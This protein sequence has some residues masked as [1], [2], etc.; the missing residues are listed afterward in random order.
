MAY[1]ILFLSVPVIG[2]ILYLALLGIMSSARV[3]SAPSV[4]LFFVF[5]GYGAVLMFM[6]SDLFRV[7]SAMHSLAALVLF[8]V[9]LPLL[10]LQGLL[11]VALGLSRAF[12]ELRSL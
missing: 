8:F 3:P 5:S 9:G 11:C 10:V 7:W 2:I 1:G 6:I 4:S 12:I